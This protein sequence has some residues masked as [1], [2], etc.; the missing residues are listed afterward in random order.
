MQT[1]KPNT[2][3]IGVNQQYMFVAI[4]RAIMRGSELIATAKSHTFARRIA[5]ALN[6]YTPG[7]RG[8]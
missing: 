6:K 8:Y 4:R 5:E 2:E 3:R 1:A 7:R